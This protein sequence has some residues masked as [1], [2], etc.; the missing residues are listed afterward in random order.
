MLLGSCCVSLRS[1]LGGLDSQH[2]EPMASCI[3]YCKAWPSCVTDMCI[4]PGASFPAAAV[5]PPGYPCVWLGV[6]S[7]S[8]EGV[9]IFVKPELNS[10]FA[11]PEDYGSD[12]ALRLLIIGSAAS[13]PSVGGKGCIPGAVY[14][15]PCA[16]VYTGRPI[17]T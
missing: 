7:L 3:G 13:S 2:G 10:N 15:A 8:W 6:H 1:T 9:G 16:D 5:L 14:P 4:I 12:R 11:I 17:N